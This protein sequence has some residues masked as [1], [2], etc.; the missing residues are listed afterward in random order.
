MSDRYSRQTVQPNID[1]AAGVVSKG[2]A[3]ESCI[4]GALNPPAVRAPYEA[5]II[6]VIPRRTGAK[7]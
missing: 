4:R 6:D 7:I 1:Q 2:A 5:R 3:A